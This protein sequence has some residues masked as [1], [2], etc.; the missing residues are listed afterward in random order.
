M[1]HKAFKQAAWPALISV[2]VTLARFFSERAAMPNMVSNVIGIFWLTLILAIYLG[3]RLVGEKRPYGQLFLTLFVFAILSRIPVVV[4][5]WITKTYALGTH[6]DLFDTW[7]Q[8]LVAQFLYGT[9]TQMVTGGIVG[10]LALFL[11]RRSQ[12][13]KTSI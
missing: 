1:L 6:Y 11:N 13:T 7:G 4:M 2:I 3:I 9:T 10:L 5:W 12:K 8:A